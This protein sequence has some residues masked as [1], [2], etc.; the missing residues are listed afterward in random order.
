LKENKPTSVASNAGAKKSSAT[1]MATTEKEEH[2]EELKGKDGD[3]R[4]INDDRKSN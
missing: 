2:H 1:V 3:K 4:D